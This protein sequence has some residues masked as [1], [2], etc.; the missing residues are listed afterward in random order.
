MLRSSL[1]P[2]TVLLI[3]PVAIRSGRLL[4]SI[5]SEPT[6]SALGCTATLEQAYNLAEAR[7]PDL[8]IIAAEQAATPEF[9][10][11]AA[12]LEIT[13]TRFVVIGGDVP[14]PGL[15]AGLS[16]L[17][18]AEIEA[19]GGL[20]PWILK[21]FG[22]P[23]ARAIA[24][25][26]APAPLGALPGGADP[27]IRSDGAQRWRT[28]VIGASTGGVEA[29][30]AVLS[31]YPADCPPTLIVQHIGAAYLTGLAQRLDR[32]C[33]A[34]VSAAT[35]T[36]EIRPGQ[37]LLAPGDTEHLTIMPPGRRCRLVAAD[38]V[39]G[40]R[41]SVDMLF[42]S[43]ARAG[44]DIVGVLLTGMGRDGARGLAA[45]RAAGGRT[46]GQDESSSTVYGMPRVA[47]ELGAVQQQLPLDRIGPAILKAAAI[48]AERAEHVR[49]R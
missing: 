12:M 3:E 19:A 2:F 28:V 42:E 45:I 7:R 14:T 20:G 47:W 44:P 26:E 18:A 17:T 23:S 22:R 24:S 21:A 4:A 8:V 35:P 30:L 13:G 43:A 15:A 40:H 37:V 11:F 27:G 32:Q 5:R 16:V 36:S 25:A 49:T 6:L 41:P 38:P 31:H 34:S 1:S 10:M 29:L 9:P 33:A 39:S 46:I 48:T